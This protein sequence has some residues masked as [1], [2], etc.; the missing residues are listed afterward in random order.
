MP[1]DYYDILG[2]RRGASADEIKSAHRKLVR[3]YHPDAN[4]H[5]PS[6][7][8]KFREAQEA[9]DVLSDPQKRQQYDTFGHAGPGAGIPPGGDYS[10]Y[11]YGA[12][13]PFHADPHDIP[14]EL[15]GQMPHGFDP[16]EFQQ[17]GGFSDIFGQLFGDRGAFG[18]GRRQ[19]ASRQTGEDD[20]GGV[21]YP[22]TLTFHQAARGTTLPVQINRGNRTD[23]VEVKIPPGV[24]SGSR[25]RLKG[26]GGRGPHGPAD[27]FI[28]INVTDHPYFKRDGIDILLDVPLSMYEA[29]LGTQIQVPTL[30]GSDTINIPAGVNSGTKIRIKG[31]GIQRGNEIGDQFVVVKIIVPKTLSATDKQLIQEFA[32]RHPVNARGDVKW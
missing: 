15:H 25:V 13:D 31:R 9:F 21:E 7:E 30:D 20:M 26:R 1:R 32:D 22:V 3:K 8:Q 18:R 28:I 10:G 14:D 4:K 24:K 12:H 6:A 23:T 29:L 27:L 5:D 2:V 17:G 16:R 19:S 11:G